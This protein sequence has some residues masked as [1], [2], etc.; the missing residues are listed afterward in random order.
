MEEV[1]AQQKKL[2]KVGHALIVRGDF[3]LIIQPYLKALLSIDLDLKAY[4]LKRLDL[5]G[6]KKDF[7][8]EIFGWLVRQ[9]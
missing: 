6:V 5:L 2:E 3:F 8:C 4:N 1:F 9:K 7:E